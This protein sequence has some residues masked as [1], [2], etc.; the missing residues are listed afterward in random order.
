MTVVV[1]YLSRFSVLWITE[2]YD[3]ILVKNSKSK[4]A[5]RT[6]L[7]FDAEKLC[8]LFLESEVNLTLRNHPR[9]DELLCYILLADRTNG[10]SIGSVASV[11]VCRLS[12][13]LCIVAKRCVLEQK[14]LL[15]AYMK[16][17][18]RNRLVPK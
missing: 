14:L 3:S 10:R 6:R 17:Y 4:E 7:L 5:S 18:M 1:T 15:I 12:V 16:S 13:T 2:F 9:P 8:A 11:V